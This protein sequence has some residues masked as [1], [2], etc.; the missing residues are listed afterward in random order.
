MTKIGAIII[1]ELKLLLRD[2]GGLIMLF[3][4]PASFI[5]I[6]SISL[7]GTF[8][9]PDKKE[10]MDILVVND[11]LGQMGTEIIAGL[12]KVGYFNVI[13]E[14]DNKKL[15]FT[16]AKHELQEGNYKI[17]INIPPET[18]DAIDFK[19]QA[20]VDVLVDPVLSNDFAA[21][22]TNAIQ[23]FIYI[24][25]IKNIGQISINIF[26]DIKS[27]RVDEINRQINETGKKRNELIQQMND[28]KEVQF[29]QEVRDIIEDLGYSSIRELESKIA[30]LNNQLKKINGENDA[31]LYPAITDISQK[32]I[33]LKVNQV[34]FNPES[35]SE[36][37]PNSVQ[38]NV[39]GWTIFA[40]FWIVQI[41]SINIISERK[42][43]AFKR[44]LISPVNTFDF[45][46]GKIIPFFIINSIQ[47][48]CMI[49]IGVF[50]LPLFGCPALTINNLWALILITATISIVAICMG[51]FFA[52]IC[53]TIFLA[54]SLS[55]SIMI[56]L[57]V[58]GGIMVPRFIMPRTMQTMG[59]FVPHGW[60]LD[61]Y[62][63]VLVK[64]YTVV[65]ILPNIGMLLLFALA[66]F[67]VSLIY[68]KKN[69]EA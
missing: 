36:T 31:A 60:A 23:N 35:G 37:F 15:T 1:K 9:S 68:Y 7:Q 10:K 47:A 3:I 28:I 63:N 20:I 30:E 58:I 61:G 34:Y 17:I 18:T 50:I 6:L 5:F 33:G 67:I 38:Q 57:A 55:A 14:K 43:G 32:D 4:L 51:L 56:I 8:S 45:F 66:F 62:L 21:H 19:K 25:I 2:P 44:I 39:P 46:A 40:L 65:Q 22:I 64:N 42:S 24:S 27:K 54:A 41:L 48:V 59:L 13:H 49:C 26:D 12:S 11:D 29:K 52:S 53:Q 69:S 16:D